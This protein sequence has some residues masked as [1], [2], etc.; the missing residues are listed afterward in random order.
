MQKAIG[1][2][3]TLVVSHSSPGTRKTESENTDWSGLAE[4][5]R[6]RTEGFMEYPTTGLVIGAGGAARAALYAMFQC[7]ITDIYLVNRMR[8]TAETVAGHY[9]PLFNITFLSSLSEIAQKR[10]P[11]PDVIIGTITA[12]KTCEEDFP[13]QIF[14][15]DR[16]IC[17]DMS[18]KPRMTPLL[19]RAGMRKG[20]TVVTGVEVLMEQ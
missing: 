7:G 19:E 3:N 1:A 15:K 5:L 8:S 18:Y 4:Y 11:S 16:G 12:D 14:A 6:L 20:W 2:V 17:V 13:D 9:A 10:H